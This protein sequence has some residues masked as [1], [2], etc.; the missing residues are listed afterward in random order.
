ML[1]TFEPCS[2]VA[3]QSSFQVIRNFRDVR[4]CSAVALAIAGSPVTM[5]STYLAAITATPFLIGQI[6][7]QR[8]GQRPRGAATA[9]R[10]GRCPCPGGD[11]PGPVLRSLARTGAELPK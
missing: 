9:A 7:R 3:V 8:S 5:K 10:S 4:A 2:A 1:P 11:R 6:A